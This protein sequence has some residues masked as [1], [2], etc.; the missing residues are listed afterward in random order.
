MLFHNHNNVYA[1]MLNTYPSIIYDS[2]CTDCSCSV[3]HHII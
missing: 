2:E 1:F 3:E